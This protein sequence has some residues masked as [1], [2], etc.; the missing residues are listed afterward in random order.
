MAAHRPGDTSDEWAAGALQRRLGEI[1]AGYLWVVYHN[2]SALSQGKVAGRPRFEEVADA[3]VSFAKANWDFAITDDQV[4]HPGFGADSGDFRVIPDPA[5]TWPMPHRSDVA[6]AYGWLSDQ[7]GEPWAGDPRARLRDA[8]AAL[9][10]FGLSCQVALE[11]EFIL[12]RPTGEGSWSPDDR[13]RMFVIDEIDARWDWTRR[14]VDTLEDAG[15]RVHQFAKEYGPAQYELSLLPTDPVTAVDRFLVARHV[16]KAFARD[17][18]LVASFMPKPWTDVP[19]NGLHA[20]LSLLDPTGVEA[21][22]DPSRADELSA[23]GQRAVAGLLA[24]ADAQAAL[25]APTRNSYRRLQPGSWAPAHRC[26]AF[27]NRAALVRIPGPGGGRHIEYRLGDATANP[28]VHVTG[29]L[30]AIADGLARE[31]P[32]PDPAAGLDVGHLEDAE[33]LAAGFERLPDRPQ[34]A[35]DALEADATLRSAL[36]PLIVDHYLAVKRYEVALGEAAAAE[37]HD[38]SDV[39]AWERHAYLEAV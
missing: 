38:S 28:Y 19:A 30:A 17:V 35:F 4:P 9:G 29:L 27:G 14:L 13:A 3:G 39:P 36:G 33:A 31:L 21:L 25:G 37:E 16:I 18:G 12:V 15:I 10:S 22:P 7:G 20:H 1:G 34:A 5:A 2:Y 6:L 26:W 11:A 23:V 8:G 24:H 32:L